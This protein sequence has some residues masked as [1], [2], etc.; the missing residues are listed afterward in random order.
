MN[1][2]EIAEIIKELECPICKEKIQ[3]I[4]ENDSDRIFTFKCGQRIAVR[5]LDSSIW[6]MANICRNAYNTCITERT[7][8]AALVEGLEEALKNWDSDELVLGVMVDEIR[9]LLKAAKGEDNGTI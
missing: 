2:Q 7:T 9:E 3:D 4:T 5:G 8:H 6:I 1:I